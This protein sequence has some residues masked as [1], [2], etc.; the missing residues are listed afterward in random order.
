MSKTASKF[1]HLFNKDCSDSGC[2]NQHFARK[3]FSK[4]PDQYSTL[5]PGQ[6][7]MLFYTP[8]PIQI[9]VLGPIGLSIGL[10]SGNITLARRLISSNEILNT[11]PLSLA[12]HFGASCP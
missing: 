1:D 10:T 6:Y 11:F 12:A 2:S 5:T 8:C 9:T 4:M 3:I 7:W